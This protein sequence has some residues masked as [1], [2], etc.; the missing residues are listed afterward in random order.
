MARTVTNNQDGDSTVM[1]EMRPQDASAAP[2]DA[3]VRNDLYGEDSFPASDA[4]EHLV[5]RGRH[6][7]VNGQL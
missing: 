2:S 6:S 3:E 4:P 7:S 1:T 5:G